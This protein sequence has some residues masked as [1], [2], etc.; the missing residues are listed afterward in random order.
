MMAPI[1][2]SKYI[3]PESEDG[4]GFD[5]NQLDPAVCIEIAYEIASNMLYVHTSP[6]NKALPLPIPS[7]LAE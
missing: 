5:A 1:I 4:L 3:D 6:Y 2:Y 7:C